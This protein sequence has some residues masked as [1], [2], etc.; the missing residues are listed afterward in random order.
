TRQYRR[1]IAALCRRAGKAP[2]HAAA[3]TRRPGTDAARDRRPARTLPRPARSATLRPRLPLLTGTGQT[4]RE[5]RTITAN[6][7]EQLQGDERCAPAS[8]KLHSPP[9]PC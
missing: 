8:S 9:P 2:G 6:M 4:G 7:A 1:A 3:A 5:R